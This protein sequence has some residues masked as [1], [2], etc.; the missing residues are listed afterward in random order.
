[1]IKKKVQNILS[2]KQLF[3]EEFRCFGGGRIIFMW[4]IWLSVTYDAER[5][6]CRR[7]EA[8]RR[9]IV[10]FFYLL[11]GREIMKMYLRPKGYIFVARNKKWSLTLKS[12]NQMHVECVI[13]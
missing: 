1:M 2:V 11:F 4:E 3:G 13:I 10:S 8:L 5:L 9:S 7:R 6:S 12:L